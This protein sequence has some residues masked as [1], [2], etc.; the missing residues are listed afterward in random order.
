MK[1][2]ENIAT[3]DHR[4]TDPNQKVLFL[5]VGSVLTCGVA[6]CEGGPLNVA[7]PKWGG[8][9][10]V[11]GKLCDCCIIACMYWACTAAVAAAPLLAVHGTPPCG[12]APTSIAELLPEAEL[13]PGIPLPGGR[14]LVPPLDT[15]IAGV[16][17]A[18]VTTVVPVCVPGSPNACP[19]CKKSKNTMNCDKKNSFTDVTD[20]IQN[21]LPT[22]QHKHGIF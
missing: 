12:P 3:G 11:K 19:G 13:D 9:Y 17:A 16:G 4:K 14:R 8:G 1:L 22:K 5:K 20:S 21:Q 7:G 18:P 6:I 10:C 15:L 2:Y